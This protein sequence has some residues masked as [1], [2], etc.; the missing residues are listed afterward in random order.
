MPEF[1]VFQNQ[2]CA[3]K[4]GLNTM[5]L[6]RLAP[7]VAFNLH[8]DCQSKDLE[9]LEILVLALSFH[10]NFLKSRRRLEAG[11]LNKFREKLKSLPNF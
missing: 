1:N 7:F 9:E 6:V 3:V 2:F 10:A 8:L 5:K 11:P 4:W